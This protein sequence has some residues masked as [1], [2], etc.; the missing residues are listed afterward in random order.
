MLRPAAAQGPSTAERRTRVAA[1]F[2]V[3]GPRVALSAAW[4]ASCGNRYFDSWEEMIEI[5]DDMIKTGKLEQ[6]RSA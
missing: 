3:R 5:L 4:H 1:V 6:A 2:S